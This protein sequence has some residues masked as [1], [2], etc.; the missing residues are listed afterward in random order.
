MVMWG[1]LNEW[2][3]QALKQ[4]LFLKD[5]GRAVHKIWHNAIKGMDGLWNGLDIKFYDYIPR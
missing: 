2:G 1:I 4:N 3:A 5:S